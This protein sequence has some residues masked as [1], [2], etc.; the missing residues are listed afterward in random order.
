M[1]YPNSVCAFLISICLLLGFTACDSGAS[2]ETSSGP[3]AFV[4]S[5]G[6]SG[7]T[8]GHFNAPAGIAVDSSGYVYVADSGNN[9]IQIFDSNGTFESN[10]GTFGG[11]SSVDG[12]FNA[13]QG[14][15]FD[16]SGNI[17]VADANNSRV[18]KFALGAT[19]FS[20]TYSSK[21]GSPGTGALQ[22]NG[23]PTGI[24]IDDATGYLW[25]VDKG[26]SRVQIWY[27]NGAVW[28]QFTTV[29]YYQAVIDPGAAGNYQ[30]NQPWGIAIAGTHA[31]LPDTNHYRMIR[32]QLSNATPNLVW[33]V[34]GTADGDLGAPMG[35]AVDSSGHVYVVE[36]SNNR[37]QEFSSSGEFITKWGTSGTGDGEFSG[38]MGIAIDD[39]NGFI[40]IADTGNNR[41]QKFKK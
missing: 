30:Y 1:K 39:T 6:S 41:I 5:W 40:Y 10:I 37:I 9:V 38:P 33:G 22:F 11:G 19:A 23:G 4:L 24:A 2:S 3:P 25:V 21:F 8:A 28:T 14:M 36:Y 29:G 7:A 16:G 31:Y 20:Y 17:Y 12:K 35:V 34:N 27:L 32:I 26:N 18:Q 13:P 15:A